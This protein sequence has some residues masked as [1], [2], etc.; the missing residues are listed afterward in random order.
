[1]LRALAA[2]LLLG[3]TALNTVRAQAIGNTER[4]RGR[5]MLGVVRENIEHQFYDSTFR[6]IDLRA[7][8]ARAD[9]QI[10]AAQSN[11]QI[12]TIIADFA[13]A[14]GDSHTRFYPP[15]RATRIEYG[16]KLRMIGDSCYVVEVE[17]GSHAATSGLKVGD[18]VLTVDGYRP[19][20]RE[21]H[22]VGYFLRFLSPRP[23][24]HLEVEGV[25]GSQRTLELQSRLIA[26]PTVT[27]LQSVIREY[28]NQDPVTVDYIDFDGGITLMRLP[29][30][31]DRFDID[32]AVGRIRDAHTLV[33]DLRGN[34]GGLVEGLIRMAAHIFDHP[35][36]IDTVRERRKTRVDQSQPTG[37]PFTGNLYVLIDSE[38][39]SAAEIFARL[40][41]LEGRG[42]VV[43]DR[44]MGAVSQ[45]LLNV[46]SIG[47]GTLIPFAVHVTVA[48]VIMSDGAGL[49]GVG[50]IPDL[51]LLPTRDDLAAERDP[52][53]ASALTMAGV[54]MDPV[55]AAKL[56]PRH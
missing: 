55:R 44:S 49:E 2:L 47:A 28:E 51:L 46:S 3:A 35:V 18:R 36:V 25:D 24:V 31:G 38:S 39:A 43:G 48:E 15:D 20:R 11:S 8:A 41:Q 9:S 10:Q 37:H 23:R 12:F 19:S 30:F 56:L 14:L 4:A 53:L 54:P 22:L 29:G 34:G 27:D 26:R 21:F 13:Q 1:M 33:L 7:A 6:G 17:P 45:A 16:W 32:R 52:V 40:V 42:M 50:V 5:Y